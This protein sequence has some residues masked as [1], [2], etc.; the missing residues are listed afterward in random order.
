MFIGHLPGGYL[1]A[2]ALWGRNQRTLIIATMVGAVLPD[3]DML[4][5]HLVDQGAVHHHTYFTHRPALWACIA[6]LGLLLRKNIVLALGLG[7]L[8]HMLLDSIVGAIAWGWP[9]TDAANPLV[10]V[11]ATHKNWIMSFLTHW[12]FLVEIGLTLVAIGLAVL[13]HH[14]AKK[15][16]T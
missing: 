2:R 15:R 14:S 13:T 10:T 6:L 12:T 1:A 5:F 7:G 8:V 9:F 4:W 16:E 3:I 11:P